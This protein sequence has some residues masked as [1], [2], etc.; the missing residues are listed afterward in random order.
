MRQVVAVVSRTLLLFAG[1]TAWVLLVPEDLKHFGAFA[2]PG[3]SGVPTLIIGYLA[4]LVGVVAG[5]GYRE[6]VS[7]KREGQQGIGSF[8]AFGARVFRSF[9]LWTGLFGSPAVYALILRAIDGVNAV[10]LLAIALENGFFCTMVIN[11]LTQNRQ[12]ARSP[13]RSKKTHQGPLATPLSGREP[14]K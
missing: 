8:R 4:T 7:L 1:L 2:N 3:G 12:R 14:A 9:D 5:A 6:T 10:G 13:S 11:E